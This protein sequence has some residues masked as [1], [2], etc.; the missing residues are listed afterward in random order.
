MQIEDCSPQIAEHN[1]N[2]YLF[3][4]LSNTQSNHGTIERVEQMEHTVQV[5]SVLNVLQLEVPFK[6]LKRKAHNSLDLQ[7]TMM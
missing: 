2:F 7:L 6:R 3:R 4:V 5:C 1:P